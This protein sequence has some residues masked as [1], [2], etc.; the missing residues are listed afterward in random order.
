MT[1]PFRSATGRPTQWAACAAVI[2]YA[3][4][5]FNAAAAPL[6]ASTSPNLLVPDGSDSGLISTLDIPSTSLVIES[7]QVTLDLVAEPGGAWNGDLYV[8]LAHAG[9]LSVLVNRP[10]VSLVNPFGYGDSGLASVTFDDSAALG[11]FHV[12]QATLGVT[13]TDLPISGIFQPDARATDPSLV[14]PGDP[15]T[16]FLSVFDDLNPSGEWRLFVADL[17]PGGGVRLASWQLTI[18]TRDAIVIPEPRVG[19]V[20]AGFATLVLGFAQRFFRRRLP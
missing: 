14:L 7:V 6:T 20:A 12:Y 5:S 18:A 4:A 2:A 11:D 17:S 16:A 13:D 1:T 9:G 3:A 19:L 10:G 15:R 8:Y